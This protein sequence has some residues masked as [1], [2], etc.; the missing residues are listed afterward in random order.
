MLS[1]KVKKRIG[2][3]NP[4]QL[5]VSFAITSRMAVF[6]GPSGSGKTLTLSCI[7]GLVTPDEGYITLNDNQLYDSGQN[8]NLAPQKRHL[9]YMPQD[10]GLFPHLTLLEN[11]AYPKSGFFGRFL[12][13]R[14]KKTAQELLNRFGLPT[15]GQNLPGELSGGQKQR[16][17][18][19]RALNAEP[20]LLLLDEPFSALDPLLRIK[21]RE[22]MLALL[23]NL[24][25]PLIV[26]THDPEDVDAFGDSVILFRH[27]TAIQVD[28][29]RKIRANCASS[30]ECL[31]ALQHEQEGNAA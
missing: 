30:A 27:G 18:L 20:S 1:L 5:D 6:F 19:A 9:G 4:F 21:L 2:R 24:S 7:A 26:I 11:V 22:E 31:L 29:Y 12:T 14:Q 13:A 8:I 17:A 10:Y 16:G 3:K 15:L 25:L 23:K 28:D